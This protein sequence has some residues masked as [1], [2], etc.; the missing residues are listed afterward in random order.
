MEST[1]VNRREQRI[2]IETGLTSPW[3]MVSIGLSQNGDLPTTYTS[4]Y[5]C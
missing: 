5:I 3:L 1:E 2:T 4:M